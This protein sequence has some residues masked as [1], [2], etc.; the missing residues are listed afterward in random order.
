MTIAVC[1]HDCKMQLNYV[2]RPMSLIWW[3]ARSLDIQR[4]LVCRSDMCGL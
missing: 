2:Y 3:T 4:L 1:M